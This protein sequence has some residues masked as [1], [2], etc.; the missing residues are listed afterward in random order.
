MQTVFY[1]T[2]WLPSTTVTIV[3]SSS[4]VMDQAGDAS[5]REIH[6]GAADR[7]S[8]TPPPLWAHWESWWVP[9]RGG[10]SGSCE[11]GEERMGSA[12]RPRLSRKGASH[13]AHLTGMTRY[14]DCQGEDDWWDWGRDVDRQLR[15]RNGR[16]VYGLCVEAAIPYGMF[17]ITCWAVNVPMSNDWNTPRPIADRDP[18]D[19]KK[20]QAR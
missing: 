17:H 7:G 18:P 11:P 16:I 1:G 13:R 14:G 6:I 10:V 20:G 4:D 12:H 5:V 15:R 2:A 3:R 9:L 8:G 19:A